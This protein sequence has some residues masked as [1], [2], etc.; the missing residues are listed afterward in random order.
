MQLAT[1]QGGCAPDTHVRGAVRS[2]SI[3]AAAAVTKAHKCM[4]FGCGCA[5]NG[6]QSEPGG[7]V[8]PGML[9]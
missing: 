2:I 3:S 6:D 5:R 1:R 8:A 7:A 9:H 4:L